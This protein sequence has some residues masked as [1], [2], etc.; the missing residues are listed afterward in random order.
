[1]DKRYEKLESQGYVF[2]SYEY[3]GDAQRLARTIVR[4]T[5][6]ETK[7]VRERTDTQGLKLYSVWKKGRTA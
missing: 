2:E 4:K 5:G 7:L 3:D 6:C 1:M